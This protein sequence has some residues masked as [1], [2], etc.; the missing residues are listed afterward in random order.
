MA[1][2]IFGPLTPG[3]N[4]KSSK[5]SNISPLFTKNFLKNYCIMLSLWYNS[6]V[7]KVDNLKNHIKNTWLK[8]VKNLS[9]NYLQVLKYMI[10]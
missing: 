8:K 7:N 5:K 3:R 4:E 6:L 9:K 2:V 1:Y 10:I